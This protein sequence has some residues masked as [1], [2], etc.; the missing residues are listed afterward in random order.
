MS[1][2]QKLQTLGSVGI[3][4]RRPQDKHLEKQLLKSKSSIFRESAANARG[5][6]GGGGVDLA[7]CTI[8]QKPL[9]SCSKLKATCGSISETS[10]NIDSTLSILLRGKEPSAE[11]IVPIGVPRMSRCGTCEA[12][13]RR[14]HGNIA[15][16][17]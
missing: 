17:K 6:G 9:Q 10:F 5:G 12:F 14:E 15:A 13:I 2:G 7:K 4:T 16:A 3:G 1:E 8:L 11:K